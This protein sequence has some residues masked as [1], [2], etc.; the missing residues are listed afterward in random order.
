MLRTMCKAKI[1]GATITQSDLRYS[2]SITIDQ[3]LIAAADILPGE[4]VQVLCIEN[5]ARFE[6]YVIEG[7][8]GSGIIGLNGPAARQALVGDTVHI[9]TWV[10]MEDAEARCSRMTVVHVDANNQIVGVNN[11]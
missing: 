1:H 4:F 2:G 11:V 10:Q 3:Q 7:E 5:G 8:P 6:T 9:L